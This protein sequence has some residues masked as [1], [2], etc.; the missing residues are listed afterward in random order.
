[1]KKGQEQTWQTDPE[2]IT[3]SNVQVWS[4]NGAMITACFPRA[5][6]QKMIAEGR[7]FV[8]SSQAIGYYDPEPTG[9]AS[10]APCD[11][12]APRK[13]S[14]KKRRGNPQAIEA[15]LK[16]L[17]RAAW[18]VKESF[19]NSAGVAFVQPDTMRLVREALAKAEAALGKVEVSR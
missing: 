17:S 6:A 1:M 16:T 15:A 8:I 9:D 4:S 3:T 13:A 18:A 14:S 2:V 7:A 11:A 19:I 12:P 10:P 5:N